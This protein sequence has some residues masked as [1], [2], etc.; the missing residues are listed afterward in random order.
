MFSTACMAAM[1]L[2]LTNILNNNS[3]SMSMSSLCAIKEDSDKFLQRC[4]G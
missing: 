1:E 3:N 2:V 4:K